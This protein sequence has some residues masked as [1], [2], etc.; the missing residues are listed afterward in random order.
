MKNNPNENQVRM[1]EGSSECKKKEA[2]R[3]CFVVYG[4]IM[5]RGG[6]FGNDMIMFE[7]VEKKQGKDVKQAFF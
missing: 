5:G 2:G 7:F 3:R 1:R 4:G 6:V